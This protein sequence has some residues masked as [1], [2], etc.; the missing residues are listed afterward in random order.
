MSGDLVQLAERYVHLSGELSGIRDAMKRLLLNGGAAPAPEAKLKPN[1]TSAK[2]PGVKGSQRQAR[3][4][5]PNALLAAEAEARI[6]ALLRST[7]GMRPSEIARQM[8]ARPNT[9][10][11]RLERMRERGEVQRDDQGAYAALAE[12]RALAA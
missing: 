6:I 3:S 8:A 5:H 9:T 11:Q 12:W 7:P 1:P 4:S 2:R 10:V